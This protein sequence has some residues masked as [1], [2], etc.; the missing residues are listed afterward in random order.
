MGTRADSAS[1][2]TV[3]AEF[4]S[5]LDAVDSESI[6]DDFEIGTYTAKHDFDNH[7]KT[8]VFEGINPSD[9]LAE[10]SEKTAIHDELTYMAGSTFSRLTNDRDYRAVV[11]LFFELLHCPQLYH[12]RGVQRKR[13]DWLDRAVIATDATNLTIT[14]SVSV[15]SERPNDEVLHEID[16]DE[17][18]LHLNVSA[19]VDGDAKHSLGVT[20]TPGVMREP[21]QFEH[22]QS[23]VE[24]FADL[25][26]PIH[27]FD[28]GYPD[29][30]R[31]C[32]FKDVVST[33]FVSSK[34]T[35]VRKCLNT[36]KM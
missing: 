18:G 1:G 8:A 14:R 28:R 9:S 6:A 30:S 12:Q 13:F 24:V 26:S 31:F 5:L 4:Y 11:R 2:S 32:D 10:L 23:D 25:D 17:K 3:G 21:T 29:Y 15:P 16:P 27:V 35:L 19:R 33:S 7:L 20:I 36:S 22:L 34:Q